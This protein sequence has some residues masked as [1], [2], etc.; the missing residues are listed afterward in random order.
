MNR[1]LILACSQRKS[2]APEPLPALDRYDGPAFRVL[3]KYLREHRDEGLTVFILSAKYGLIGANRKIIDYDCRLTPD[4]AATMRHKVIATV[5]RAMRRRRA[6]AIGICASR[7]YR[8]ALAGVE[9]LAPE[10]VRVSLIAGGQG[11]RLAALKQ[12]L[13]E[14][15]RNN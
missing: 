9:E 3:R 14:R 8:R 6:R 15:V 1:I 10:N 5:R 2:R 12:W 13:I 7:D 4:L 11:T